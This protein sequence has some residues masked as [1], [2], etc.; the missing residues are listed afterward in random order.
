MGLSKEIESILNKLPCGLCVYNL[1][2]GRISPV[3]Q[4]PAF[5]SLLGYSG[6]HLKQVKREMIFLGVHEE[7]LPALQEKINKLILE[8]I[9]LAYIC[10]IFNEAKGEYRWIRMEGTVSVEDGTRLFYVVYSDISD[11]KQ[12]EK[13]R[14]SA[15]EKMQDIINAIPGGVAVYKVSDIFETI[16]FSDGVPQL[17]GYQIP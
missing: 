14:E 9:P 13:E 3:F 2:N 1:D 17:S 7:D 5:H 4:N 12:L 8:G 15:N 16:Y 6:E 10:R 11:Q